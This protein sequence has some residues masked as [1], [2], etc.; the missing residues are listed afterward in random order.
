[1]ACQL[2]NGALHGSLIMLVSGILAKL[3]LILPNRPN[4]AVSFFKY[5][6]NTAII[7]PAREISLSWT[8]SPAVFVN[9]LDN[10]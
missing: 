2:W 3:P 9:V 6:E 4:S 5:S 1:M 10:R 8:S 7:L